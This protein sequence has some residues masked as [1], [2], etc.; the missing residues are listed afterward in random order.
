MRPSVLNEPDA[1]IATQPRHFRAICS[2]QDAPVAA[3]PLSTTSNPGGRHEDV[4]S[5][6]PSPTQAGGSPSE[7]ESS[8]TIFNNGSR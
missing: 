3:G 8:A 4:A 2:L 6:Q 1:G 5:P 7:P